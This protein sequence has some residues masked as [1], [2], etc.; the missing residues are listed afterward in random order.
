MLK[1]EPFQPYKKRS[2]MTFGLHFLSESIFPK[3]INANL[4][5]DKLRSH[6]FKN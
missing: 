3:E 4:L 5:T 1:F 6:L 2:M